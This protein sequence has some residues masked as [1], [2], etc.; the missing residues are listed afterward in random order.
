MRNEEK[1]WKF[2]CR[3]IS[4]T[5]IWDGKTLIKTHCAY[6]K[7]EEKNGKR[8]KRKRNEKQ[9][10]CFIFEQFS[11]TGKKKRK[12]KIFGELNCIRTFQYGEGM[13][14]VVAAILEI[15]LSELECIRKFILNLTL[16]LLIVKYL[17]PRPGI[18]KFLSL[19][20]PAT[21]LFAHKFLTLSALKCSD[22]QRL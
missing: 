11:L 7:N 3:F 6:K 15:N 14:F 9:K 13:I 12:R 17:L 2:R 16:N 5:L 18:E 1:T 8:I 4:F 19:H 20:F 10:P 21:L 22:Y